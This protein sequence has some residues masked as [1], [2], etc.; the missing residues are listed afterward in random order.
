[1][2]SVNISTMQYN[3]NNFLNNIAEVNSSQ[4]E[5]FSSILGKTQ[6][7]QMLEGTLSQGDKELLN[8]FNAVYDSKEIY[9][10]YGSYDASDDYIRPKYYRLGSGNKMV[11]FPTKNAT[12]EVK[13]A[14]AKGLQNMDKE[15]RL[16]VHGKI[17]SHFSAQM[18]FR[19][20]NEGLEKYSLQFC[21][22][23]WNKMYGHG[24]TSYQSV[25][26]GF[27]DHF[28]NRVNTT[29]DYDLLEKLKAHLKAHETML[30]SFKEYGI[31]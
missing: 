29:T 28:Q 6:K 12:D 26:Q 13:L 9:Q 5:S 25:F 7:E 15:S 1:M 2:Q 27:V 22:D 16:F 11:F 8:K 18:I 20:K 3:A 21:E 24:Q 10:D 23:E 14:F 17:E 31:K 30:E 19:E 4:N